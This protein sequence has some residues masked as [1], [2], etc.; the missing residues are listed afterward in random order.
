MEPISI[1]VSD[2]YTMNDRPDASLY[3]FA[4]TRLFWRGTC[5]NWRHLRLL[6]NDAA[7]FQNLSYGRMCFF[8]HKAHGFGI[9]Y[10]N[11]SGLE[12]PIV[13]RLSL[14]RNFTYG[15]TYFLTRGTT[16]RDHLA[17][18]QW[19]SNPYGRSWKLLRHDNGAVL[20]LVTSCIV[21]GGQPLT[22][23][24]SPQRPYS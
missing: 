20:T 21:L 23:I 22:G 13:C 12:S 2:S 14:S 15:R 4:A 19:K 9:P 18:P 24:T 16:S 11:V 8:F 5:L 10:D 17:A 1:L 6:W 7:S 3:L